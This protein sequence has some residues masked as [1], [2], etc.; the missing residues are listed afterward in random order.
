M[1]HNLGL[2][3]D[4]TPPLLFP[5]TWVQKQSHISCLLQM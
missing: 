4:A 5:K 1:K 2:A 3:S